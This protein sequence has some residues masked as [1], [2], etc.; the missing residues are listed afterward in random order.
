MSQSMTFNKSPRI[1]VTMNVGQPMENCWSFH[2]SIFII[3]MLCDVTAVPLPLNSKSQWINFVYAISHFMTAA[4]DLNFITKFLISSFSP[5]CQ[6]CW[7]F[8]LC[9]ACHK[10]VRGMEN[11]QGEASFQDMKSQKN[12]KHS[13]FSWRTMTRLKLICFHPKAKDGR[14]ICDICSSRLILCVQHSPT[15]IHFKNK[16]LRPHG[17]RLIYQ[18]SIIYFWGFLSSLSELSMGD[19]GLPDQLAFTQKKRIQRIQV[20]TRKSVWVREIN[21]CAIAWKTTVTMIK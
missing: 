19:E 7:G 10:R 20:E 2:E 21:S 12:F 4:G 6:S 16:L 11:K 14:K 15:W 9:L 3:A 5:P 8:H 17:L 18:Q 13:R 1:V